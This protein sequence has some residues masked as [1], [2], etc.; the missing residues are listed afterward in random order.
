MVG[1]TTK[2]SRVLILPSN[3]FYTPHLIRDIVYRRNPFRS[4]LVTVPVCVLVHQLKKINNCRIQ[5]TPSHR[6]K[7]V[8]IPI[9]DI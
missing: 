4:I 3:A 7:K 8:N 5:G 6:E 2:V 9:T 1:D